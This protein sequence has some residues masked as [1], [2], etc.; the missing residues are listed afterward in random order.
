MNSIRVFRLVSRMLIGFV[1]LSSL[2]FAK[3]YVVIVLVDELYKNHDDWEI[4]I[5]ESFS[6]LNEVYLKYD[7]QF[8]VS[9]IQSFEIED[10]VYIRYKTFKNLSKLRSEADLAIM[11]SGKKLNILQVRHRRKTIQRLFALIT[12]SGKRKY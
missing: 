11:F 10:S 12:D 9:S 2:A 5:D 4:H 1:S 6:K 3:D 7:I 8:K